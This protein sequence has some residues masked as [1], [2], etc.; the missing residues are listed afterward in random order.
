MTSG[1]GTG[2][3]IVQS[4]EP[5]VKSVLKRNPNYWKEGSAHF[6]EVELISIIDPTARQTA[7]MS[8]DIDAMDR[9][10]LKTI[11]LLQTQ[12]EYQHHGKDRDGP[13]HLP[14]AP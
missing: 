14:D 9:V 4:F 12:S 2:G 6:D 7:L 8:G 5:G 1:I 10:D 13:L 11:N 3:Y